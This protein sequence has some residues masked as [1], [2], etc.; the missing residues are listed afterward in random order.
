MPKFDYSFMCNCG[1]MLSEV[2][3]RDILSEVKS[4]S[5]KCGKRFGGWIDRHHFGGDID[6]SFP[7]HKYGVP[8]YD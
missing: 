2:K 1:E 5:K 8:K 3:F 6:D 4:H 7:E